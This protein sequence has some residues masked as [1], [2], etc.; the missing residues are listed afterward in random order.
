[1]CFATGWKGFPGQIWPVGHSVENPCID[2]AHTIAGV[3]RWTV[4]SY[5]VDMG[6]TFW[7]G[8][9]L[10][11]ASKR[12]PSTPY[13]HN[14]PKA[15]HEEPDHWLSRGRQ[16]LSISLWH[17]PRISQICWRVEICYVMLWPRQKPHWVS[18][19]FGSIIF[20]TSWHTLFLGGLAKR[21]PSSWY[22]HT[23]LCM[24]K[25]NLLI[26]RHPSKT[27]C[28]LQCCADIEIW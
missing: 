6:T 3:Q 21:C 24:G 10:V 27:L 7:T 19:S 20:A 16:N 2:T 5:S 23:F 15:F 17:A 13:S 1:M 26:F 8:I 25:I 12:Y 22:I 11:A 18:S 4:V 14:T 9:Q 28:H